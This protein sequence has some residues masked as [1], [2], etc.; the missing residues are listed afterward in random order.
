MLWKSTQER[1]LE[2]GLQIKQ[3]VFIENITTNHT[4]HLFHIEY[5][6]TTARKLVLKNKIKMQSYGNKSVC[7]LKGRKQE[8]NP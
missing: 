7:F 6:Q 5:L 3:S 2:T 1:Q 4:T 8:N